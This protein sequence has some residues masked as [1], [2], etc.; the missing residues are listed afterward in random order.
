[1]SIAIKI[2]NVTK[3]Y[4]DITI[5]N[6]INLEVKKGQTVGIIGS[7]GSGKSV[8]FKV[9]CGFIS[10]DSGSA[11]IRNLKLGDKIDFPED[12][13]VFINEPGYIS[14]YNGFQNLKF[15]AD[16]NNKID[17]KR[18]KM[19][20]EKVGLNP[21]NKAKVQDY[22]LGMKQKL[23][24]AQAIMEDQDIIVLDEPFN[25]L[26]YKTYDDI[27][28][29]V[30]SLKEENKTILLTSHNFEDIE[31]LCDAIYIIEEGELKLATDEIICRYR[32]R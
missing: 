15:L 9:I 7:N 1:M 13:G 16:I 10:P 24:I 32:K 14:I 17:D 22:S 23:G 11:Y 19:T 21:N 6:N 3:S 30:K 18:I 29:I 12:M 8:L 25:A 20:M 2:E 26:D 28:N 4:N 27:K 31:Q 5:L